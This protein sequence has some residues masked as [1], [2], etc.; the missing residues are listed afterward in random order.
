[1]YATDN[2]TLTRKNFTLD[3]NPVS[4]LGN[5]ERDAGAEPMTARDLFSGWASCA[6]GSLG[7][8][9]RAKQARPGTDVAAASRRPTGKR[10]PMKSESATSS[11]PLRVRRNWRDRFPLAGARKADAPAV[12]GHDC[13]AMGKQGLDCKLFQEIEETIRGVPSPDLTSRGRGRPAAKLASGSPGSWRESAQEKSR[14]PSGATERGI[15]VCGT[16]MTN[17]LPERS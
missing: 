10:I 12:K 7:G 6:E 2:T 17:A 5:G 9:E 1:M 4:R 8:L 11:N 16:R 3:A 13:E 14:G 15:G